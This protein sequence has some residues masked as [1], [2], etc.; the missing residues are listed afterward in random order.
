MLSGPPRNSVAELMQIVPAERV[1][2][3][4]DMARVWLLCYI[5]EGTE[6]II[7][8]N[9]GP[10]LD[11]EPHCQTLLS[12]PEPHVSDV[13]LTSHARLVHTLR[14]WFVQRQAIHRNS[15]GSTEATRQ[16]QHLTMNVN[17]RLEWWHDDLKAQ[18]RLRAVPPQAMRETV[19]FWQFARAVVNEIGAAALQAQPRLRASRVMESVDG[20]MEFLELCAA[21][22]PKMDLANLPQNY[23]H[24][25]STLARIVRSA[26]DEPT[27]PI[28]PHEASALLRTVGHMLHAGSL[29]PQH[30]SRNAAD[31]CLGYAEEISQLVK[32]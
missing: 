27:C 2:S 7:S 11:P 18:P 3:S 1:A 4:E 8:G 19:L 31:S 22:E 9:V 25:V 30:N 21:W 23:L 17:A 12:A 29:P 14:E 10:G 13:V 5:V 24:M 20:A 6:I 32:G 15:A 28:T 16:M 26:F